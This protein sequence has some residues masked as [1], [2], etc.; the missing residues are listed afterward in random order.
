MFLLLL[1]LL[2]N[3]WLEPP[4]TR[5]IF[6]YLPCLVDAAAAAAAAMHV[7]RALGTDGGMLACM[8]RTYMPLTGHL[9]VM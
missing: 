1:L 6:L 4:V 2:P 9:S 7:V 5:W 8:H 3:T